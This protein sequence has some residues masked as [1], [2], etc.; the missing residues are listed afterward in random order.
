MVYLR[1]YSGK[2]LTLLASNPRFHRTSILSVVWPSRKN[3]FFFFKCNINITV[4]T[5]KCYTSSY[6]QYST[7]VQYRKAAVQYSGRENK[8]IY[9]MLS[10]FSSGLSFL[11]QLFLSLQVSKR[12]LGIYAGFPFSPRFSLQP[13][14]K[15]KTLKDICRVYFFPAPFTAFPQPVGKQ[16]TLRDISRVSILAFPYP[17][18]KQ[19]TLRDISRVSIP[20]FPQP[21][22]K[23]NTLRDMCRVSFLS[24]L[25]LSLQVSKIFL[26]I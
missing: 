18:G 22:G 10:S 13:I 14:G 3:F 24:Q 6:V 1:K 9:S 16:K 2:F 23:Q 17:I 8:L 5:S 11:S 20:A 21:I 19:N 12:L 25:F 4:N 15:Q 26:G 7:L